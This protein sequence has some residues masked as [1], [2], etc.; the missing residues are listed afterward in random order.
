MKG[1]FTAAL[2]AV[3]TF[4]ISPSAF[5]LSTS[6]LSRVVVI[7]EST[8]INEKV[9]DHHRKRA[10]RPRAHRSVVVPGHHVRPR[11]GIRN[12]HGERNRDHRRPRH[13]PRTH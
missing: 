12:R 1:L 5:A 10:H 4:A 3:G 8:S 13:Q 9:S 7:N 11:H 6:D 2:I